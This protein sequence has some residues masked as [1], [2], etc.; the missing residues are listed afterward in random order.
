MDDWDRL[1]AEQVAI[2]AELDRD[3]RTEEETLDLVARLLR[4]VAAI[5]ACDSPDPLPKILIGHIPAATDGAMAIESTELPTDTRM[6]DWLVV[7]EPDGREHIAVVT[8]IGLDRTTLRILP[9]DPTD[10]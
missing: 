7:A 4:N 9:D 10:D 1:E 3:D 2:Q 6:D 8:D 5:L